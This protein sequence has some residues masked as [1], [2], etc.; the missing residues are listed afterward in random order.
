MEYFRITE[1]DFEVSADGDIGLAWG[2]FT[3]EFQPRGG[4]PE[5]VRVRFTLTARRDLFGEWRQ[6]LYH[7]DAQPFDS[8]GR[9]LR[10]GRQ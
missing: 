4:D 7:R 6:L 3:E 9:Y 10:A 8:D 2:F 1:V 5:R